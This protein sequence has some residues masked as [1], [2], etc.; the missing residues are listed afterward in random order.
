ME[1]FR[2]RLRAA[3]PK[4]RITLVNA[5]IAGSHTDSRMESFEQDVLSHNPDLITVEFVN[6]VFLGPDKITANWREFFARA[7]K[8]NPDVEF[9][10][11]TPHFMM[12]DWMSGF[13]DAVAAMRKAA[14]D[15]QAAL[16]DVS[17]MYGRLGGLGIPYEA[18]LA[19]GINHPGD[20]GHE[21]FAQTLM[22]LLIPGYIG[23]QVVSPYS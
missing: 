14:R 16:G 6:D 18:L 23:N 15:N 1:L 4:S 20:L 19:N 9:L 3:Y 17:S 7:R 13:D 12:Q 21:F 8:R 22:A 2:A 10:I 5:G 11:L